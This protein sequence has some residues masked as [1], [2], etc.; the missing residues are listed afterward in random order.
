M[1][2]LELGLHQLSE[3]RH[4]FYPQLRRQSLDRLQA[5]IAFPAFDPTKVSA[6]EAEDIGE[7]FL[8]DAAGF[9]NFADV[10]TERSL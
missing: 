1:T 3:Q 9:A 8:A 7:V 10:A 6:V 2:V 4:R 5:E